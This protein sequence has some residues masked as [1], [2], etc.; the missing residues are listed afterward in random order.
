MHHIFLQQ[1]NIKK[2]NELHKKGVPYLTPER[3]QLNPDQR[4]FIDLLLTIFLRDG[5]S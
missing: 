3:H 5:R 2:D 4:H 1:F